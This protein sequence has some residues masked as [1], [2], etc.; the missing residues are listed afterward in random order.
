M[1]VLLSALILTLQNSLNKLFWT[2][3]ASNGDSCGSGWQEATN[4]LI[5]GGFHAK[6]HIYIIWFGHIFYIGAFRLLQT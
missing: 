4:M 6:C 1:L 2:E 5:L 3:Q